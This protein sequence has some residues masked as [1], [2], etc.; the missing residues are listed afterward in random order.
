[1]WLKNLFK[2][3]PASTLLLLMRDPVPFSVPGPRPWPGLT[4]RTAYW[5]AICTGISKGKK[6]PAVCS[7]VS[8]DHREC[9]AS[10]APGGK[11]GRDADKPDIAA[12]RTWP[13]YSERVEFC[14]YASVELTL[15]QR[16]ALTARAALP[17]L[18]ANCVGSG[19]P[20][21]GASAGLPDTLAELQR[22]AATLP[23][24][25]ETP[26]KGPRFALTLLLESPT[27]LDE[28]SLRA[29]FERG[30]QMPFPQATS[31]AWTEGTSPALKSNWTHRTG[32]DDGPV[33]A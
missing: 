3:D 2:A 22:I 27:M 23:P 7:F 29:A 24:F 32:A 33:C 26:L 17:F 21:M 6:A 4:G 28:A 14:C 20:T 1:M 11:R 25:K 10:H 31:G 18:T 16:F 30:W 5:T 15:P 19:M 8:T 13:A 9:V 12:R